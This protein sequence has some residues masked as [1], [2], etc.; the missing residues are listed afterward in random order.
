MVVPTGP[1]VYD[2]AESV[3]AALRAAKFHVEVDVSGK[4]MNQKIATADSAHVNVI[5]IVGH[6]ERD[7][8]TVNV[9]AR[10]EVEG[11]GKKRRIKRRE[12][13]LDAFIAEMTELRAV[14]G[15]D[16]AALRDQ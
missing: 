11:E 9:R 8:G 5:V 12:V 6:S 2:Y 7:A 13:A 10:G 16:L 1:E 3:H 15:D 14:R 4:S